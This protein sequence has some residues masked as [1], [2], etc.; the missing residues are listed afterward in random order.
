MRTRIK[1]FNAMFMICLLLTTILG[2]NVGGQEIEKDRKDK[3]GSVLG[4]DFP[5]DPSERDQRDTGESVVVNV[6]SYE[7]AVVE[8]FLLEKDGVPVNAYLKGLTIGS[9]IGAKSVKSEPFFGDLNIRNVIVLEA[10]D[11]PYVRFVKHMLP[12]QKKLSLDNLGVAQIMLERIPKEEDV[13]DNIVVNLTARIVFDRQSGIFGFGSQDLR[14]KEERSENNWFGGLEKRYGYSINENL[15]LTN[16][17]SLRELAGKSAEK[18]TDILSGRN[19][20][21]LI[22]GG[23]TKIR[24]LAFD[25]VVSYDNS[26]WGGNGY[27]RLSKVKSDSAD[28]V[29]YDRGLRRITSLT[30]LTKGKPSEVVRFPDRLAGVDRFRVEL[31]DIVDPSVDSAKMEVNFGGSVETKILKKGD[32]IYTGSR[33]FVKDIK[34][35]NLKG[36]IRES[37]IIEDGSGDREEIT[38]DYGDASRYSDLVMT[39]S[40]EYKIDEKDILTNVLSAVIS[41]LNDNNKIITNDFSI[42]PSELNDNFGKNFYKSKPFTW[43]KGVDFLVVLDDL[44][45]LISASIIVDGGKIIIRANNEGTVCSANDLLDEDDILRNINT[46]TAKSFYCSAI[47][48]YE[49]VI[50]LFENERNDEGIL[51]ADIARLKAAKS[52]LEL[53]KLFDI[54]N[55]IVKG[56]AL[57]LL[58]DIVDKDKFGELD[59]LLSEA[60][61]VN[62]VDKE[63][64]VI[65]QG[66]VLNLRLISINIGKEKKGASIYLSL[67]G[68]KTSEYT[69]GDYLYTIDPTSKPKGSKTDWFIESIDDNGVT[70]NGL[71]YAND[72]TPR[73]D[74]LKVN[75]GKEGVLRLKEDT[76][77]LR[78]KVVDVDFNK[79]VTVRILPGVDDAFSE[80]NFLVRIPIEKRPFDLNP[81]KIDKGIKKTEDKIK[82]L[83]GIINKLEK[84]VEGWK[85]L[86]LAV[87]AFLTIKNSF[88][89]GLAKNQAR[90]EVVSG[91]NGWEKFCEAAFKNKQ[92]KSVDECMIKNNKYIV[93][94][95]NSAQKSISETNK[96]MKQRHKEREK[97][98]KEGKPLAVSIDGSG[99]DFGSINLYQTNQKEVLVTPDQEREIRYLVNLKKNCNNNRPVVGEIGT[100]KFSGVASCQDVDQKLSK[101]TKDYNTMN[102]K[103]EIVN[104]LLKSEKEDPNGYIA[105]INEFVKN[106]GRIMEDADLI[107]VRQAAFYDAEK[108][109]YYNE[110]VDSKPIHKRGNALLGKFVKKDGKTISHWLDYKG[111]PYPIIQNGGNY[112]IGANGIEGGLPKWMD[113]SKFKDSSGKVH[114]AEDITPIT[115]LKAPIY[116]EAGKGGYVV[117]N[118]E[119]YPVIDQNTVQINGLPV[120]FSPENQFNID[121][122]LR[123]TYAPGATVEYYDDGKPFCVPMSEGNYVRVNDYNKLNN[124]SN[125]DILNV[126]PDGLLCTTDDILRYHH[127]LLQQDVGYRGMLIKAEK[128]IRQAASVK[129]GQYLTTGGRTFGKSTRR[130]ADLGTEAKPSCYDVMNPR[131]CQI[132][133]NVCDPVMCPPSRFNL[134]GRWQLPPGQSVVQTG[135]IGSLFLGWPIITTQQ[136]IPKVCMTGILAGL[137]N[138]RS[139]LQGYVRCLSVAKTEGKSVGICDKIRSVGICEMLWKEAIALFKIQGGFVSLI[140]EKLFK[141][142]EGGG[143]YLTFQSSLKNVENSVNFFTNEYASTAF[144]AFQGRSLEDIGA[145]ICRSAIFGRFPGIDDFV[146]QLAKPESPPQFTAFFSEFTHDETQKQSR[147]DVFYH[148]YAGDDANVKY[149]LKYSVYLRNKFG[150]FF[151]VTEECNKRSSSVERNDFRDIS[152]HCVSASNLDEV[153][154]DINGVI[155]CGFGKVTSSFAVDF[156]NDAIVKNEAE[157]NIDDARDCVADNP[158]LSPFFTDVVSNVPL[159][160]KFSLANTG[161]VRVCSINNPG[162]INTEAK[163]WRPVGECGR[164]KIGIDLGLCWMDLRSVSLNDLDK[165]ESLS[166]ELETR[167]INLSEKTLKFEPIKD[168]D[169]NEIFENVKKYLETIKD[170][171]RNYFVNQLKDG[172]IELEENLINLRK[173][174]IYSVNP[175]VRIDALMLIGDILRE[176][177]KVGV[178]YENSGIDLNNLIVTSNGNFDKEITVKEFLE[179]IKKSVKEYENKDIKDLFE[180]EDEI[181]DKGLD[182]PNLYLNYGKNDRVIDVLNKLNNYGL[183]VEIKVD[184]FRITE[185]SRLLAGEPVQST[186]KEPALPKSTLAK[187][188]PPRKIVFGFEKDTGY[189]LKEL[190]ELI[191]ELAYPPGKPFDSV[192]EATAEDLNKNLVFKKDLVSN[193]EV[194]FTKALSLL[195]GELGF[196]SKRTGDKIEVYFEDVLQKAQ[197]LSNVAG[198]LEV[199]KEYFDAA[200]NFE[201]AA[202]LMVGAKNYEK[203]GTFYTRSA[204]NY[205]RGM[206]FDKDSYIRLIRLYLKAIN[207]YLLAI[208]T[209]NDKDR[210]I[211]LGADMGR[212]D[213][214]MVSSITSLMGYFK[215]NKNQISFLEEELKEYRDSSLSIDKRMFD[216]EAIKKL[217]V[218]KND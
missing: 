209:T 15:D 136:P 47:R 2:V 3:S 181:L 31:L 48:E 192:F 64:K 6:D 77:N 49:D 115:V 54:N 143:E 80:S 78:V 112:Y 75:I 122:D 172:K 44:A 35:D 61:D 207:N 121:K 134:G 142:T 216:E 84:L 140:S 10:D 200:N 82:K 103:Y 25:E 109:I 108:V 210:V 27:L 12:S 190:L 50:N 141:E 176:L 88:L 179:T 137:K 217:E 16:S 211:S 124:P 215:K 19:R 17:L 33:W 177:G 194:E 13:P 193:G 131:D 145:D 102:E 195:G 83:T 125:F 32:R 110:N 97:A 213:N 202:T 22:Y 173:L 205:K 206:S 51:Y 132:M 56:K 120:K 90:K 104:G 169:A 130:A 199:R 68:E 36:V 214:D 116:I 26:F 81:K 163:F 101:L 60:S 165:I 203:A 138:I 144:T 147:Y 9:L 18:I 123:E 146:D 114:V 4:S 189:T 161:I 58:N 118:G 39:K 208:K 11:N 5:L 53:S 46:E 128:S 98:L 91:E 175:K 96:V 37:V 71:V 119:V 29:V 113:N 178:R 127:S 174:T 129:D 151:Y 139:L 8:A 153:C 149:P 43:K 59:T 42:V 74:A 166:R 204:N 94:D 105:K 41:S 67:N 76:R 160:G 28:F 63:I 186:P 66:E 126:G 159:P 23:R 167:G 150:D 187:E 171:D 157:R 196:M 107:A 45:K 99:I 87:F 95:I 14:L 162:A 135:I 69:V 156:V 218:L 21:G 188:A 93:Q 70:F 55:A 85:K 72:N 168:E 184:R 89:G 100:K 170:K 198:G 79:E 212:I 117:L 158:R 24:S 106:N 30:S 111:T 148:L 62:V 133:F 152:T 191:I 57:K 154:V 40:G 7:P 155:E 65:E 185:S 164:D 183:S 182:T 52:Y 20:G 1:K 201:E 86:C 197:R 180:I 38:R 73:K 92:Y 34:R